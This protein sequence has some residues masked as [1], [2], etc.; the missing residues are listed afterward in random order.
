MPLTPEQVMALPLQS[1]DGPVHLVR[2]DAAVEPAVQALRAEELL[3]F[4]LESRPSFTAGEA[5]PPALIQLAGERSVHLFQL[6]HLRDHGPLFDLLTDAGVR[7]A[8]L[9]LSDDFRKLRSVRDFTPAGFEDVSRLAHARGFAQ[10]GLRPLAALLL[11]FRVS[12]SEQR[13]NWARHDLTPRQIR[14]AATDAWV[15][16]ELYLR[17]SGNP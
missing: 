6:R 13:S 7:K 2:D 5:H 17:L 9:G 1:F 4:D 16:R 8:G 12:K 11:G 15:T 14:Y 10:T 3:G